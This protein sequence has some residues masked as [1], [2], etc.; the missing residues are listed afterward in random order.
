MLTPAFII[1]AAILGEHPYGDA[2]AVNAQ[3]PVPDPRPATYSRPAIAPFEPPSN[4]GRQ[5]AQGDSEAELHRRPLVA[6]VAV[7]AYRRSYEYSPSDAE[8]AYE[9]GVAQARIDAQARMGALDGVWRVTN[10]DGDTLSD[11]VVSDP[12][13]AAHGQIDA[14]W[15]IGLPS[16]QGV[17]TT[18]HREGEVVIIES[19]LGARTARLRLTPTAD[20]WSGAFSRGGREQVVMLTR[21]SEG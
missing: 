15:N 8:T 5:R 4:F 10:A 16:D 18:A 11:L 17:P 19:G 2:A 20:G 14:A 21:P 3:P 12:G 13:D 6:P 9:Q 1:A 7:D